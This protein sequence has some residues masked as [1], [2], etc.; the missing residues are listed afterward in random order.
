MFRLP[1]RFT[2]ASVEAEF[3]VE[4]GVRSAPSRRAGAV[5]ALL[6][7][8]AFVGWDLFHASENPEFA[9]VL[10]T[11]L[12][13]RA[14]GAAYLVGLV[15]MAYSPRMAEER[16]ATTL[17][18]SG[19]AA[20]Y[21]L[22]LAMVVFTPFPFNYLY[23]Y[24][25]L[26]LVLFFMFG[27][28]KLGA[29]LVTA[30][31]AVFMLLSALALPL[32]ETKGVTGGQVST[33]FL[34]AM[35]YLTAFIGVGYAVTAQLERSARDAFAR[36]RELAIANAALVDSRRDMEIKTAALVAAKED[37]RL[38]AEQENL[39]KSKF[40]ADAA[41]DLR[42]PMQALSNLLE[43]AAHALAR[44]DLAKSQDLLAMAR[45]ASNLTR[46]AFNAVL[47][48]SRL[49]S[50]F[51]AA[52]LTSF[53]LRALLEEVAAAHQPQAAERGVTLRLRIGSAPA[54]VRSDRHL[55]MRVLANLVANAVK[56][57]D[58]TVLIGLVRFS[59]RA[60]VDIVDNG[61]GIPRDQWAAIFQPFTQLNNPARDREKG[62]GLGLSIVNAILPLLDQHRLDMR[63]V[64][65]QG[66]R[67]SLE[68]PRTDAPETATP[69]RLAA[70]ATDAAGAY[71]LCV[72]DD[73]LVRAS[74][75]ALFDEH[76]VL[77]ETAATLPELRAVLEGMERMPD[78]ILTDWRLPDGLTAA[79]VAATVRDHFDDVIPAI[80]MTGEV[81]ELDT[82]GWLGA[83]VVL[84]KPVSPE[85]LLAE[86]SRLGSPPAGS[87]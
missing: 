28:L 54:I 60:R 59:S 24:I 38:L 48:V 83:G 6:T 72:E 64:E 53:D 77:Y 16:F 29:R 21:L 73:L 20:A 1:A 66:T 71:V 87:E 61:V 44:Q 35:S 22:L 19:V 85:A 12:T 47:D 82:A 76:Q 80:V 63:S 50:G 58:T 36:E 40:L 84:R 81:G 8:C 4:Y 34:A 52:E 25:G 15:R 23:Y 69:G 9:D 7:W 45:R 33:Y 79:Q 43:A 75:T 30:S 55:L 56:Y 67:F 41:H 37:L 3:L 5:L 65:N 2:P 42:Q 10:P 68:V 51:V 57:G 86:I 78:V 74:I 62:M 31:S 13:L 27:V 46:Q 14:V 70:T 17:L 32:A 39:N 18:N 26:L 49:E 11:V